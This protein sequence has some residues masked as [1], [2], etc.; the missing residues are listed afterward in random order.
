VV[1]VGPAAAKESK[2]HAKEFQEE[3]EKVAPKQNPDGPLWQPGHAPSQALL[4]AVDAVAKAGTLSIIGVYP[5]QARSFPIG[6][7]MGKNLTIKMGN[8][9]HRRYIPMLVDLVRS[10]RCDPATILT[11]REPLIAALDAYKSFDLRKPG[12]VK[13]E[14]KPS[15]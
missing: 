10:G 14:L 9:N 11:Q 8:C 3:L 5:E 1:T 7:A 6:K 4:W 12:W 13:V 15:A 2:Q